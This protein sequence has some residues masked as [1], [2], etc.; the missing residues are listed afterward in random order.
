MGERETYI[1][2]VREAVEGV[3]SALFQ[4][5]RLRGGGSGDHALLDSHGGALLESFGR[6]SR[7][8]FG[9]HD[10]RLGAPRLRNWESQRVSL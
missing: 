10:G 9:L 2:L 6:G 8:R 4:K 3:V 5:L 1:T 7:H